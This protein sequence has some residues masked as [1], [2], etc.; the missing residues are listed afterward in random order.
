MDAAQLVAAT[1][2]ALRE[3]VSSVLG[4]VDDGAWAEV[5]GVSPQRVA[6]WEERRVEEGKRRD[7]VVERTLIYFADLSDLTTI[8]TKRWAR[9]KSILGERKEFD[10]DMHR[11]EGIRISVAHGRELLAHEGSDLEAISGRIRNA[12]TIHRTKTVAADE[13]FPRLEHVHDSF[14]NSMASERF[15]NV[16]TDLVLRPGDRVR[17]RSRGWDPDGVPFR[18]EWQPNY[19]GEFI[20]FVD[21]FEWE[22]SDADIGAMAVV[23]IRLVSER[24]YHR[25]TGYDDMVTFAYTV[26]PRA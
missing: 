3:L 22:V 20:E 1:E 10:V 17:F 8:I 25:R 6:A 16:G 14:G 21:E 12:V 2:N 9:F 26:L 19:V 13:Y 4:P 18:L 11:L 23:V 5:G 7:A 24:P 15:G